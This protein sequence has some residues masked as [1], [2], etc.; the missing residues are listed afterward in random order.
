MSQSEARAWWADVEHLRE[1]FERRDV[2]RAGRDGSRSGGADAADDLAARRA[3]RERRRAGSVDDAVAADAPSLSGDAP[4]G[5]RTVEIR[6]HAVPAPSV[7]R[8]VEVER[9]RPARRPVERVGPRPDRVA[10]W[11]LVMALVLI[12]VAVGSADAAVAAGL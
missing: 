8:L 10:A 9:R 1:D 6:G 3:V 2:A 12:L 7:R 5:R 11:A 4:S